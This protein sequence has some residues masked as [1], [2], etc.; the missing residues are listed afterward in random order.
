[1]TDVFDDVT[2][3]YDDVTWMKAPRPALVARAIERVALAYPKAAP[4][5]VFFFLSFCRPPPPTLPTPPLDTAPPPLLYSPTHRSLP[6]SP[7]P[8]LLKVRS[9]YTIHIYRPIAYAHTQNTHIYRPIAYAHTQNT[10]IQ[11]ELT[12]YIGGPCD[13]DEV[14]TCIVLGGTGLCPFMCPHIQYVPSPLLLVTDTSTTSHYC[15]YY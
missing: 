13:E 10:H 3:V 14:V 12:H 7:P 15:L 9:I 8:W 4:H 1:V 11:V 6:L 2:Y 5:K